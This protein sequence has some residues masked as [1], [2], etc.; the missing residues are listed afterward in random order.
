MLARCIALQDRLARSAEASA[1]EEAAAPEAV[2]QGPVPDV[3]D[4]V[5]GIATRGDRSLEGLGLK[6]ARPDETFEVPREK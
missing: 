1:A 4:I 2:A 3:L 5:L 6:T